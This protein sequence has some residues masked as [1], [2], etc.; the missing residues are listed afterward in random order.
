MPTVPVAL[1][2]EDRLSHVLNASERL[3]MASS[4]DEVVAVLRDTA[5]ATVD[6]QGVAVVLEDQGRCAYVAEDAVSALWQGQSF[7]A[8][9]CISGWVLRH[10]ETAAISDVRVDSRI[11][12]EAYAPTFVRSLV[13]V[14][15]GR[16]VPVAALGAYWRARPRYDQ[17]PGKPGAPG[18]DCHR[19]RPAHSGPQSCGSA[20]GCT[21]PD[22][23]TGGRRHGLARHAGCD[24]A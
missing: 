24:R 18:D 10:G 22:S 8:D 13:M 17:T 21:E 15:I 12:Q 19:E 5:R 1:N 16:P 2:H 6:A 4:V 14:P 3:V 9:H 7:A 23:R 11:P 20:G